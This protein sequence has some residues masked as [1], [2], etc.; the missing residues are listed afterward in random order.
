VNYYERCRES[1]CEC[2]GND[3]FEIESEAL[4]VAMMTST[5]LVLEVI[6]KVQSIAPK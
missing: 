5:Y 6:P 3:D 2:R 4:S 1:Q